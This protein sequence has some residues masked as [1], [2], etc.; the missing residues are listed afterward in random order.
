M[1][2]S[3]SVEQLALIN[4]NFLRNYASVVEVEKIRQVLDD[5]TV[6]DFKN[7][8][9][10]YASS[11]SQMTLVTL[12][13]FES[14]FNNEYCSLLTFALKSVLSTCT[15]SIFIMLVNWYC[16]SYPSCLSRKCAHKKLLTLAFVLP[17]K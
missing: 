16:V 1:E 12:A 5:L 7:E 13:D 8:F 11:L 14:Q 15:N 9:F 3:A 10:I 6:L 17:C 4:I 2:F